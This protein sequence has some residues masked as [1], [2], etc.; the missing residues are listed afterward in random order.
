MRGF[1]CALYLIGSIVALVVLRSV[2]K[3]ANADAKTALMTFTVIAL[4]FSGISWSQAE[5]GH[6]N[7]FRQPTP[8]ENRIYTVIW[9]CLI[10][11][12]GVY[13]YFTTK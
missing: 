12:L 13:L 2:T 1:G 4:V 7:P 6:L 11:A 8:T 10:E 3:H 9:F 5:E